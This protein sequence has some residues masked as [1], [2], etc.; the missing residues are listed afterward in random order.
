MS[1]TARTATARTATAILLAEAALALATIVAL[2]LVPDSQSRTAALGAAM[3]VSL[4]LGF[5]VG[6][7]LSLA[8]RNVIAASLVPGLFT[9]AFGLSVLL[10]STTQTAS[11]AAAGTAMV[12]LAVL[13]ELIGLSLLVFG[14][15]RRSQRCAPPA[16]S[17]P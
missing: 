5:I 12:V 13:L 9:L 7:Q 17:A 8:P 6:R 4:P 3:L 11:F 1:A 10:S 16:Q 15:I 14:R 2:F